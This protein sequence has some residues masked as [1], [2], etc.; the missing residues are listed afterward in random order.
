[1]RASEASLSFLGNGS[2]YGFLVGA[3]IKSRIV[4]SPHVSVHDPSIAL[5]DIGRHWFYDIAVIMAKCCHVFNELD[6]GGMDPAMVVLFPIERLLR[7]PTL[8]TTFMVFSSSG[9]GLLGNERFSELEKM[10]QK[11]TPMMVDAVLRQEVF[12]AH[13][14]QERRSEY[15]D[16]ITAEAVRLSR[17]ELRPIGVFAWAILWELQSLLADELDGIHSLLLS[18]A[19]TSWKPFAHT[20][21]DDYVKS[22][23][24]VE[25]DFKHLET[26]WTCRTNVVETFTYWRNKQESVM[27]KQKD[28]NV[29]LT[30]E[31]FLYWHKYLGFLPLSQEDHGARALQLDYMKEAN[32]MHFILDANPER[33]FKATPVACGSVL[34]NIALAREQAGSSLVNYNLTVI[35]MAYIYVAFRRQGLCK[36][37]WEEMD[38]FTQTHMSSIFFGSVPDSSSRLYNTLRLRL[39]K[40][41]S[42]RS[43]FVSVVFTGGDRTGSL[44]VKVAKNSCLTITETAMAL[45]AWFKREQTAIRSVHTVKA[46]MQRLDKS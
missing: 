35:W 45:D 28:A 19:E 7:L 3:A 26:M 11:L 23:R 6:P 30:D 29:V 38:G 8:R 18:T 16:A 32:E 13:Q 46:I 25:S 31:D 42:S 33:Y 4:V 12:L 5:T 9:D 17:G 41:A 14:N 2:A 10:D 36:A 44:P 39:G 15:V 24:W 21:T 43:D 34:F 1:M 37:R 40:L 27:Q 22:P 20:D